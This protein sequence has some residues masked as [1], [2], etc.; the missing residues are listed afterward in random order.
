MKN[1][2]ICIFLLAAFWIDSAVADSPQRLQYLSG[3]PVLQTSEVKIEVMGSAAGLNIHEEDRQTIKAVL[4][5]D[6]DQQ[7]KHLYTPPLDLLFT[8]ENYFIDF[9]INHKK[10]SFNSDSPDKFPYFLQSY[11]IVDKPMKLHISP[12]L[13]LLWNT[14]E[15]SLG[16]M[17]FDRFLADWILPIFYLAGK[18]L[19][20]GAAYQVAGLQYEIISISEEAIN[21]TFTG[22]YQ[23]QSPPGDAFHMALSGQVAGTASW[24][25]QNALLYT[26]QA[27]HLIG[28]DFKQGD[29]TWHLN[30]NLNHQLNTAPHAF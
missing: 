23:S 19:Y 4:A 20:P 30:V 13:S 5:I 11:Q 29:R 22:K 24:N 6:A 15:P 17:K 3:I 12:E 8:V 21:A 27:K 25:R 26:L 28:A 10:G 1:Y 16:R 7:D 9:D 14:P 2:H 18:D